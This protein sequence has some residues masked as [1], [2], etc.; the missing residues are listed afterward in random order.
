MV[1][2]EEQDLK[3]LWVELVEVHLLRQRDVGAIL[4]TALSLDQL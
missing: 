3:Q 4:L 2:A 1:R